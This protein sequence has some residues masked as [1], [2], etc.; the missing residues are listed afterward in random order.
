MTDLEKELLELVKGLRAENSALVELQLMQASVPNPHEVES[1][2]EIPSTQR[3]RGRTPWYLLRTKLEQVHRK[4][5]LSEISGI[6][7][8]IDTSDMRVTDEG[9]DWPGNENEL[10]KIEDK[11]DAN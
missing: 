1:K 3:Y 5:K 2:I 10:D 6:P 4:P 11:S 7:D 8:T 9:L